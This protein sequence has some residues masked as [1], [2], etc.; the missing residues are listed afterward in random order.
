MAKQ[1]L[2]V[3]SIQ[4]LKDEAPSP[5]DFL[6]DRFAHYL[7][8]HR[9]LRFPHKHSFYQLVYFNSGAGS[10]AIDFTNFKLQKGQ[11]YFMIPGQVHSWSF[12]TQPD[13][14]IVNFS[15]AYLQ[16]LLA[17]PRYLDQF[18]FFSG[19]AEQQVINL[20][21]QAW[22]KTG[23]LLET[24]VTEATGGDHLKDDY[25]R[26][27][28]LQLFIVISRFSGAVSRAQPNQYNSVL[29]RNF[30]QLIEQ[31]YKNK[32][33]TKE[34]AAML[35]IT[36]NHLNA[37]CRDVAG[38]S[39]GE[40]IRNRVLLEAKRLLVNAGMTIAEIAAAL[41][42]DDNSYFTKFFKKYEG[43]TPENFRKE[44]IKH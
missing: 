33:L 15:E 18:G 30:Q 13:G 26:T 22:E 44:I 28:L 20:P 38:L 8:E 3:Y 29:L 6:A 25:I 42:F 12:T 4:T 37:L 41:N 19:I 2:P 39:A 35:Y 23:T 9:N 31:H 34:Y 10:H 5:K 36:P 32:R 24:I 43:V 27:A 21:K 11:I 17:N 14:Y 1:H 16:A 7:D 40:L